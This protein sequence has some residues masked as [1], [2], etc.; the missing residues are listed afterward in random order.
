MSIN[1]DMPTYTGR[2]EPWSCTPTKNCRF[3]GKR[4]IMDIY[5]CC[6]TSFLSIVGLQSFQNIQ[7]K[8][9]EFIQKRRFSV[10]IGFNVVELNI[11]GTTL[12]TIS[13]Y[14]LHDDDPVSI[15]YIRNSSCHRIF[16]CFYLNVKSWMI[17]F[18]YY[19]SIGTLQLEWQ[20]CINRNFVRKENTRN[21]FLRNK[22]RFGQL[23]DIYK[24]F[25][26]IHISF[27]IICGVSLSLS[28]FVESKTLSSICLALATIITLPLIVFYAIITAKTP[29]VKD[30]FYIHRENKLSARI[31]ICA[32]AASILVSVVNI[33]FFGDD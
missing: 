10:I 31:L 11:I 2:K 29:S 17:Y 26:C 9:A 21:W 14:Y 28:Q 32:F 12:S 18:H 5:Y 7:H 6:R 16:R 22:S 25:G 30:T 15:M 24:L 27:G 8:H 4:F 1:Y 20:Q 23:T 3:K 19:W 33:W 13:R